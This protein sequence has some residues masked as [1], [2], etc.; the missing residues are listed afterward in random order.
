VI[1]YAE[2][3]RRRKL[4]SVELKGLPLYAS[5]N[6]AASARLKNLITTMERFGKESLAKF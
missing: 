3:I 2:S 4:T 5:A 1:R 6:S